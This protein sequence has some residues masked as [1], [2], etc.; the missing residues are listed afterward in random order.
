RLGGP[1]GVHAG[2]RARRAP[3][4]HRPRVAS[5]RP[6]GLHRTSAHAGPGWP[7]GGLPHLLP[8]GGLPAGSARAMVSGCAHGLG[9]A[10]WAAPLHGGPLTVPGPEPVAGLFDTHAHLHNVAFVADR[11]GALGRARAAGVARLLTVGTDPEGSAEAV[12]LAASH[13]DVYAAVGIHPH[14]AAT[15]DDSALGRIAALA[16]APRVVAVGEIGLDHY[17]NLSPRET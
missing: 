1:R 9:P 6:S 17:R 5:R 13:A 15:A 7:D 12:A 16:T 10:D 2:R 3:P 8:Q 4:A 11:D 14:D